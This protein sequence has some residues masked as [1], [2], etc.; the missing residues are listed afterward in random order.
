M[1]EEEA[2]REAETRGAPRRPFEGAVVLAPAAVAGLVANPGTEH[3]LEAQQCWNRCRNHSGARRASRGRRRRC[4]SRSRS[5]RCRRRASG[6]SPSSPAVRRRSPRRGQGDAAQVDALTAVQRMPALLQVFAALD[7]LGRGGA[8]RAAEVPERAAGPRESRV[9]VRVCAAQARAGAAA[10]QPRP[11]AARGRP[12]GRAGRARRAAGAVLGA[13]DAGQR[14]RGGG[15]PAYEAG[16]TLCAGHPSAV[17]AARPLAAAARPG[18][19]AP[20]PAAAGGQ[21]PAG[22]ALAAPSPTTAHDR[23]RVRTAA[24]DLRDPAL[25]AAAALC[26]CARAGLS[27]VHLLALQ[28]D[29]VGMDRGDHQSA[30]TAG[31]DCMNSRRGR[32]LRFEDHESE[33]LVQRFRRTAGDDELAGLRPPRA[34]RSKCRATTAFSVSVQAASSWN[35]GASLQ[36][37]DVLP[38]R[39]RLLREHPSLT[40]ESRKS[41]QGSE[42]DF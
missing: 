9:A 40:A 32:A 14:G 6:S 3:V 18:A 27:V 33:G 19:H 8:R 16:M 26:G 12:P 7:Q 36:D 22:Q 24:R 25:P 41:R 20:R 42:N 11:A 13:R 21:E 37:V 17:R 29:R 10:G 35:R 30:M 38:P 2:A 4:S 5:T 31:S 15:A 28:G 23:R 39:R 34:S 1:A